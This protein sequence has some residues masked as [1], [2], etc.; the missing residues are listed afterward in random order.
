MSADD[1]KLE[2]DN[3]KMVTGGTNN[4]NEKENFKEGEGIKVSC[5]I[6]G[7]VFKVPFGT[8]TA[9]C[10]VCGKPIEIKS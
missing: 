6:C 2:A 1:F 4:L 8:K 9:F 7:E 10:P 5:K 3:L